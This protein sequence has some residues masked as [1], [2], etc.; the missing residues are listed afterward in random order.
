MTDKYNKLVRDKIPDIIRSKGD[1]PKTQILDDEAYLAAL[2]CKLGEEVTEYLESYS[3]EE[4]ADIMEVILALVSYNGVSVPEFEQIRLNKL[5]ERGGFGR[6]IALL[7]VQRG[8][9]I[10]VEPNNK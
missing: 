7:E 10:D 4:L 8:T 3:V 6:R 9:D 2:N 1:L 5:K